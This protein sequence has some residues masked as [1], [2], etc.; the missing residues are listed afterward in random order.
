MVFLF[1]VILGA[2]VNYAVGAFAWF[3]RGISPWCAQQGRGL[4]ARKGWDYVPILGW[5]TLRRE[6]RVLGKGFWIRPLLVEV[7]L[8]LFAVWFYHFH[9][10]RTEGLAAFYGIPLSTGE[11][12]TL[13]GRF[14][15]Q[16]VFVALMVAVSLV[17]MDEKTI[18]DVFT[19]GGTLFALGISALFPIELPWRE[20]STEIRLL[21]EVRYEKVE[22]PIVV[23]S[24]SQLPFFPETF[25]QPEECPHALLYPLSA[26]APRPALGVMRGDGVWG[27]FSAILCWW[28]W[29]FAMLDRRWHP[30]HGWRR[31]WGLFWER[32]KRSPATLRLYR[33]GMAGTL[34]ILGFW[35]F[36]GEHWFHLWSALVGMGISGGFLWGI[37]LV[38]AVAMQR[39]A[40]GF[41]DVL[42]MAMFGAFLGWQPCVVLFFLSPFAAL[43]IGVVISLLRQERE[44]PFGPFLCLAALFTMIFWEP[45]WQITAPVFLWGPAL[46]PVAVGC[47]LG[48]GILLGILQKIKKLCGIS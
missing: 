33:L 31:A 41:G 45:I 39:E 46:F 16:M 17:D 27:I 29:C 13:Y 7:G 10:T 40:M 1:G 43:G 3:P 32:L 2:I 18:P 9:V 8:G 25:W 30:R 22:K 4:P 26:T 15:F 21:P 34:V 48:M 35:L 47:L 28:G 5:L 19:V 6:S 12:W 44:I 37:R 20:E 42:L 11:M 24:I 38:S 14:L 23:Q 36:R